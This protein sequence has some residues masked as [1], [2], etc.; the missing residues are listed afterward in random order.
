MRAMPS[1][2]RAFATEPGGGLRPPSGGRRAPDGALLPASPQIGLRGQSPRS[3][4]AG[5]ANHAGGMN[6]GAG[7]GGNVLRW[8]LAVLT[9]AR[10]KP[11][12]A[13]GALLVVAML[14]MA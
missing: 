11:L 13:I 5:T 3:E 6:A 10:R 1:S 8:M 7:S 4:E 9:F 2:I 12:G 14:L